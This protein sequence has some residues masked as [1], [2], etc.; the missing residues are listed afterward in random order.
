MSPVETGASHLSR[1]YCPEDEAEETADQRDDGDMVDGSPQ[2]DGIPG[3]DVQDERLGLATTE[4]MR[5]AIAEQMREL[6]PRLAPDVREMFRN[7]QGL[8]AVTC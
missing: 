6:Y 2:D 1:A 8:I 5:K 7:V 3:D 4:R